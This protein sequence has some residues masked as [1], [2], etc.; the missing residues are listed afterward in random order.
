MLSRIIFIVL[1]PLFCVGQVAQ[2][3]IYHFTMTKVSNQYRLKSPQFLTQFNEDGYNNQPSYFDDKEIYFATDYYDKE[4]T[5]IAKFDLFDNTLTRITYT[6][7]KEYSPSLIKG[8]EAFSVI[9][10]ESDN[11]TQTLSVYPLDGIGYAKRY[12]NNTNNIGYHSWLDGETVAL[13]LVEAPHHNLAIANAISERRKIVLD[14][15]GRCLDSD[16]S[17]NL[18]FV[19]KMSDDEWYLKSYNVLTS[20]S[21]TIIKTLQGAEDFEV[22]NDGS[23]LM[24]SK[25]EL[26]RY[27]PGAT[28]GWQLISDLSDYGISNITR[29]ASRKNSL[30]IVED[31]K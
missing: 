31:N 17:G 4:Q 7:E 8:K 2:S 21:T 12:M 15:V 3:N 22:L 28:G 16:K 25:S 30:I 13:F 27:V 10:V 5:E 20:K 11:T 19:H 29:I 24:G 9:R 26:Y 1:C 18:I 6:P 23:Y 14:K